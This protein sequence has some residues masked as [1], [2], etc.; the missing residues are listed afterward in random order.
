MQMFF[1]IRSH[2]S[3]KAL[4]KKPEYIQEILQ[5]GSEKARIEGAK[6]LEEIKEA[7]SIDYF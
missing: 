3:G 6:T 2:Q 5:Y 7:M 1:C 4:E